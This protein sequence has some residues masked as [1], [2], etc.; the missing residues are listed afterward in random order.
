[1]MKISSDAKEIGLGITVQFN[2]YLNYYI[3]VTVKKK[4]KIVC[5][6]MK[7]MIRELML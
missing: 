4:K 6:D 2:T 7:E 5:L 1:M 3:S